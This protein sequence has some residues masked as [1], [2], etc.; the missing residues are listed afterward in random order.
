MLIQKSEHFSESDAVILK[1]LDWA[2]PDLPNISGGCPLLEQSVFPCDKALNMI[3][4]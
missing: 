2:S 4:D 3:E 1:G